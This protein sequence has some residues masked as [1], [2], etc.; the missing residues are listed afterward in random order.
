MHEITE[1]I[2]K[3]HVYYL[4]TTNGDQ[5]EIRPIGVFEEIDGKFF[6]A[7]GAH[8]NVYK[9]M[10]ANPKI[11]IVSYDG[12]DWIRIRAVAKEADEEYVNKVFDLNPF[13]R[14]MYNEETGNR[15]GVFELTEGEV[16]FCAIGGPV[17]TEKL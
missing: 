2:K 17:R 12:K 6:T 7:V 15:L 11:V 10:V 8:K 13:L 14:R 16:E 5:P 4:G 3:V 9:Q 1:F